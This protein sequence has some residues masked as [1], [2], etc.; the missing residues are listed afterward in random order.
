MATETLQKTPHP[1]KYTDSFIPVFAEILIREGAKNVLD[2]F[3]GTGKI[4]QVKCF[5]FGGVVYAN[6]IEPEWIRPNSYGCDVITTADAELLAFDGLQFDA[7]C[8]SPTYGNR[9]AD[10]HNAKD[11]SKRLT[12]THCLG[13]QL[14]D[15][16]TGKMQ[17]GREYM[18]KHTRIY[19][20]LTGLLRPGGV[21]IL[22]ISNHIRNGKEV[23]VCSFHVQELQAAG[24]QLVERRYITTPRMRYGRNGQVRVREEQICIMRKI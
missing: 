1:A 3:A 5:G 24:M 9:M 15:C 4:G 19:R 14:A 21:F 20:N 12:Y 16:N 17:W 23:D 2:P 22:N 11:G 13:R 8:T 6:E 7:I 18:D 10:H